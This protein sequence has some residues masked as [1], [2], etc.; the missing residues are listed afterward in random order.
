MLTRYGP[1][2]KHY[3]KLEEKLFTLTGNKKYDSEVLGQV[4]TMGDIGPFMHSKRK[5]A[6]GK[7]LMIHYDVVKR[8]Y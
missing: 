2:F 3:S 8:K 1:I 5:K 4:Q 7:L 6:I